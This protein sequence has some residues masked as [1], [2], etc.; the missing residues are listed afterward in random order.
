MVESYDVDGTL[1]FPVGLSKYEFG[2]YSVVVDGANCN[3]LV[4]DVHQYQLFLSLQS[5]STIREAMFQYQEI[6]DLSDVLVIFYMKKLLENIENNNFIVCP[7]ILEPEKASE[8][9]PQFHIDLTNNCNLRCTHCFASAGIRKVGEKPVSFWL[10][11]LHEMSELVK[12]FELVISG[13]EPTMYGDGLASIIQAA[14]RLGGIVTLFT[15]GT[16]ISDQFLNHIE[17]SLSSAQ[18]SMEAAT[19][20]AYDSIRGK[21]AF[22]KF[23]QGLQSFQERKIPVTLA[24]TVLDATL[25]DLDRSLEDFVVKYCTEMTTFRINDEV[26]KT[27]RAETLNGQNFG[28]DLQRALRVA[29]IAKRV[30]KRLGTQEPNGNKRGVKYINCGIGCNYVFSPSGSLMP[31][32]YSKATNWRYATS[33]LRIAKQD[34]MELNEKTSVDNIN[35][36][37]NCD[38]KYICGGGCRFKHLVSNQSMT[39]P[40][41]TP[42]FKRERVAR[43]I[44]QEAFQAEGVFAC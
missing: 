26:E 20:T 6:T 15:N 7:E 32:N 11:K 8:I 38:I 33:E 39:F 4:C 19:E 10:T 36:C 21:G 42:S 25:D 40:N 5:G 2:E 24:V 17:G 44:V 43:L 35:Q 18:L 12:P 3:W 13:G 16:R 22:G 31:C 29:H 27:G 23:I 30:A 41:C 1:E 9:V 28:F 37:S 14:A 34:F